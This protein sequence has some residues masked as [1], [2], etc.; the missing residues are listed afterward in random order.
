MS[1]PS[2]IEQ[3]AAR[4]EALPRLLRITL[5]LVTTVLL[6]FLVWALL[7]ELVG[8]GLVSADPS[9]AL[10]LIVALMG[11]LIYGAGWAA[12]VGFDN[13]PGGAWHAGPSAVYFLAAGGAALAVIVVVVVILLA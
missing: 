5:T 6:V 10:T 3:W 9:P 1:E 4:I 12:L 8:G 7:A 2:R 11:M 13:R